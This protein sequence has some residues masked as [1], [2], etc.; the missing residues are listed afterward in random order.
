MPPK[1]DGPNTQRYKALV[2]SLR[3]PAVTSTVVRR[4]H[5]DYALELIA[6][7]QA[8]A[9][10]LDEIEAAEIAGVMRRTSLSADKT[11]I[12]Q[13]KT[14]LGVVLK[15]VKEQEARLKASGRPTLAL[16]DGPQRKLLE[17]TLVA[18][19]RE[20]DA[21]ET[22]GSPTPTEGETPED[23]KEVTAQAR[24]IRYFETTPALV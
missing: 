6:Q 23:V 2:D 4:E 8:D 24:L 13:I 14:A 3:W 11:T 16:I 5:A 10:L 20:I 22:N 17:T 18:L 9:A 19:E 7:V 12:P 21:F 1:Q 15:Y